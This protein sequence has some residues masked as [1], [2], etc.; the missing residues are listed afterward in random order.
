MKITLI[1]IALFGVFMSGAA[2]V[3][4]QT[5]YEA[6]QSS[7]PQGGALPAEQRAR[8]VWAVEL[9]RERC[10]LYAT[11]QQMLNAAWLVEQYAAGSPIPV[12]GGQVDMSRLPVPGA[13]L[14]TASYPPPTSTP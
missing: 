2:V 5:V 12:V 8:R 11:P 14:P 7:G 1:L 9:V 3:R 10:G 4:T 13:G 6:I